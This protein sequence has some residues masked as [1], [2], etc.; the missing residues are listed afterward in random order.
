MREFSARQL[1]HRLHLSWKE[2][3]GL[4]RFNDIQGYRI[5]LQGCGQTDSLRLPKVHQFLSASEPQNVR[6]PF[7]N[8][9]GCPSGQL[10]FGQDKR[11][12]SIP[13][14]PVCEYRLS[15]VAVGADGKEGV[16]SV[17][18]LLTPP[19]APASDAGSFLPVSSW[20]RWFA[21]PTSH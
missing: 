3:E 6:T 11:S 13:V 7:L 19:P 21:N 2:P 14:S 1:R 18:R 10:Y 16:R 8:G 4:S 5:L 9:S 17:L 15:A 20:T 12:V